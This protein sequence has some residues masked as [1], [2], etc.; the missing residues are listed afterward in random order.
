MDL[1]P[2]LARPGFFRAALEAVIICLCAASVGLAINQLRRA[3]LALRRTVAPAA[4]SCMAAAADDVRPVPFI[5]PTLAAKRHGHPGVVFVDARPRAEF[6]E[7]HIADAINLPADDPLPRARL[8]P[9]LAAK[10]VVVYCDRPRCGLS[11]RLGQRLRELGVADVRVLA[12]G[13]YAWN[14]AG[15]PAQSGGF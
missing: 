4:E 8:A 5:E 2:A 12:E 9:V 15:Y 14:A 10:L 6:R 7:A 11:T 13:W 3:P 1:D